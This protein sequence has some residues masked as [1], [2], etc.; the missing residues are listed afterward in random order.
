MKLSLLFAVLT[1]LCVTLLPNTAEAKHHEHHRHHEHH[2]HGHHDRG[3]HYGH[4][5]SHRVYHRGYYTW[6]HHHRIWV[7]ARYVVVYF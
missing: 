2:Y 3:H 7:P 6:R 5:R 1:A 4:Y